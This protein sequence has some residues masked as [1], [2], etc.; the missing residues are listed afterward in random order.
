MRTASVLMVLA[1]L[2]PGCSGAKVGSV[3]GKVT[4]DGKP[5]A[6]ARVNF[7]PMG[8]T[9]NTGIG[10]FGKADAN[11]QYTLSLIDGSATGAIVGKHKVAISAYDQDPNVNAADDRKKGPAD[12]VPLKYN[13]KTE[14][15]FDVRAGDNTANF[16]LKSR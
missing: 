6:N 8:D 11:G 7:Q 4:L 13:V 2:L 10:S 5:L 12:R 3:S 15:I 14:L 16:D 1:C 9:V